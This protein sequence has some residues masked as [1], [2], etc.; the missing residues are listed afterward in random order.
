MMMGTPAFA[1]TNGLNNYVLWTPV[2]AT[3]ATGIAMFEWQL[4]AVVGFGSGIPIAQIG[5]YYA[6]PGTSQATGLTLNHGMSVDSNGLYWTI[7]SIVS[8]MQQTFID[9]S[10][11]FSTGGAGAP[12]A[13]QVTSILP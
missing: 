1:A 4:N 7:D 6:H 8:P 9:G 2:G 5:E 3:N 13:T 11:V 12:S 10:V